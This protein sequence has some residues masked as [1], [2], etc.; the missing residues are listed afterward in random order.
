MTDL[1]FPTMALIEKACP[2]GLM[3]EQVEK[4]RDDQEEKIKE[5]DHIIIHDV[6]QLIKQPFAMQSKIHVYIRV[7]HKLAKNEVED[8]KFNAQLGIESATYPDI[9]ELLRIW[10]VWK[11]FLGY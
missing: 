5:L 11:D 1:S 4:Q 6:E 9:E 2:P 7:W 8:Y 3:I 10:R